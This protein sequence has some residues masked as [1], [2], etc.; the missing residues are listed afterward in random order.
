MKG[1]PSLPPEDDLFGRVAVHNKLVT[2][3]RVAEC[4]RIIAGEVAAGLPRRSLASVLIGKG[5]VTALAAA[6]VQKAVRDYAAKHFGRA[7]PA[8]GAPPEPKPMAERAPSGTS[9]R[10]VSVPPGGRRPD[11]RFQLS[12]PDGTKGAILSVECSLLYAGDAPALEAA[13]HKLLRTD[14][15]ELRLDLRR[16]DSVPSVVISV[17]GKLAA[18]AAGQGRNFMLVCT[19]RTAKMVELVLGNAVKIK[20]GKPPR[21]GQ[22]RR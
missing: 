9:Q 4:A 7:S 12:T 2:G 18:D 11:Q 15:S 22:L 3:E 16:V 20:T 21:D 5:Y 1:T 14:R 10:A 13:V 8:P 19:E 17:I 6:A